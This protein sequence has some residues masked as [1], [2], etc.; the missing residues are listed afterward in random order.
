MVD[1]KICCA[2]AAVCPGLRTMKMWSRPPRSCVS[3]F[4]SIASA[5]L[6]SHQR[7]IEWAALI[8]Y[9]VARAC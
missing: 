9:E 6:L 2:S 3:A 7:L 5:M 1:S 8:R 4:A